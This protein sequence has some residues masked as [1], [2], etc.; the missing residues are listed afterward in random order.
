M[1]VKKPFKFHQ[2]TYRK[3]WT[4]FRTQSSFTKRWYSFAEEFLL[5]PLVI[6]GNLCDEAC[7]YVT[8]KTN[9]FTFCHNIVA[10]KRPFYFWFFGE[11]QC[12]KLVSAIFFQIFIFPSSPLFLPVS[13]CFRGCSKIN[14]K[15]YD[16]IN[17]LNKNLIANFVWYLGKEKRCDIETLSIDRVLN[18][19]HFYMKI[20]KKMFTRS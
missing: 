10:K 2:S 8:S 7:F 12:L 4:S 20:M 1:N 9:I 5:I 14:L 18:Q 11:S 6:L 15:V 13:H 17:C 3:V 16:V 19:E